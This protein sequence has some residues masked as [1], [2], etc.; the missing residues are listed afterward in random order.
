MPGITTPPEHF[1]APR[2]PPQRSKNPLHAELPQQN[3]ARPDTEP[4]LDFV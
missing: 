2:H 4:G 1:P 3:G